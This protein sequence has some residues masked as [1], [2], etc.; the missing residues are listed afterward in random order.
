MENQYKHQSP[1]FCKH[2]WS[3]WLFS[4]SH[5]SEYIADFV[6]DGINTSYWCYKTYN[7]MMDVLAEIYLLFLIQL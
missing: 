3:R 2:S 7:S 4:R 6:Q 5:E 1:A